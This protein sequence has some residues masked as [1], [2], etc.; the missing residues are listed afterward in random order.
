MLKLSKNQAK[1]KQ[2]VEAE[3]LLFENH[4]LSSS[5]YRLKIIGDILKYV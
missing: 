1:T 4:P 3:P 5:C 2:H